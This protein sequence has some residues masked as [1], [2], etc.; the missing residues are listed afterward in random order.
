MRR[1][2]RTAEREA[3]LVLIE[4]RRLKPPIGGAKGRV[5][6]EQVARLHRIVA[7]KLEQCA[8][9]LVRS[10]ASNHVDL[11]AGAL[12]ELRAITRRLN[13][14]LLDSVDRRSDHQKILVLVGVDG[15]VQQ[16]A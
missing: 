10:A 4:W 14:E 15:S 2:H 6:I 16:K 1:H 3:E 8:M 9:E 5:A 13:F 11:P 7:V 12:A